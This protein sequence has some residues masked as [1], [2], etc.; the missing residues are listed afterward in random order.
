MNIREFKPD[1]QQGIWKNIFTKNLLSA[2]GN[3]KKPNAVYD[4]YKAYSQSC[5]FPIYFIAMYSD[6]TLKTAFSYA[7]TNKFENEDS[8]FEEMTK[9]MTCKIFDEI[10]LQLNFNEKLS[11][12]DINIPKLDISGSPIKSHC[13]VYS[14]FLTTTKG[15]EP[16]APLNALGIDINSFKPSEESITILEKANLYTK[17][18]DSY[19][20]SVNT[21][22]CFGRTSC[23]WSGCGRSEVV[24]TIKPTYTLGEIPSNRFMGNFTLSMIEELSKKNLKMDTIFHSE[25]GTEKSYDFDIKVELNFKIK[26]D[27]FSK[28]Y[29]VANDDEQKRYYLFVRS[30]TDTN[31]QRTVLSVSLSFRRKFDYTLHKKYVEEGKK[32]NPLNS[33]LNLGL[34]FTKPNVIDMGLSSIIVK[35]VIQNHTI[36][37]KEFK[38]YTTKTVVVFTIRNELLLDAFFTGKD[39]EIIP[40]K[41]NNIH[42]ISYS[43][44]LQELPC[45]IDS[46]YYLEFI[47][48][49]D[50]KFDYENGIA[51]I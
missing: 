30:V 37:S 41:T 44:L 14:K 13:K 6:K 28:C 33:V 2:Y 3:P 50:W 27:S 29:K 36:R 42:I 19:K 23:G 51:Y 46:L 25:L 20:L 7:L 5:G 39:K 15:Y 38:N 24:G 10:E 16:L 34:E 12:I 22:G 43:E 21:F 4:V 26:E 45:L 49:S 9:R 31:N 17:S 8:I 11:I 1:E 18:V 32:Y 40:Y 35:K 48:E 47:Q